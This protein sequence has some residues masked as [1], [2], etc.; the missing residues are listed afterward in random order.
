M[1]KFKFTQ[2]PWNLWPTHW[3]GG[4]NSVQCDGHN[5]VWI[6]SPKG[7]IC[8]MRPGINGKITEQVFADA[9]LIAKSPEMYDALQRAKLGLQVLKTMAI[10]ENLSAAASVA[11]EQIFD[12]EQ[13]LK[14][15]DGK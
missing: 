13:L 7:R 10:K 3:A 12:I 2:G 5:T 6:D 8:N 14:E 11:S 1:S 4:S 9:R 15:I